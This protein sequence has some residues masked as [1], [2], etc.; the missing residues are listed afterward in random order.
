MKRDLVSVV[1]LL[2]ALGAALSAAGA[3][4]PTV[5][6]FTQTAPLATG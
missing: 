3:I 2:F 1:F 5:Q 4:S 6:A